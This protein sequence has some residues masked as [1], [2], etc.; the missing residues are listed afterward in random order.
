MFGL[1]CCVQRL[2]APFLLSG[3]GGCEHVAGN[4]NL[5]PMDQLSQ[6][7]ASLRSQPL[8]RCGWTGSACLCALQWVEQYHGVRSALSGDVVQMF[9]M[10]SFC[11]ACWTTSTRVLSTGRNVPKGGVRN[12][13]L[14]LPV[15]RSWPRCARAHSLC[16]WLSLQAQGKPSQVVR[17]A[18]KPLQTRGEL[19]LCHQLVQSHGLGVRRQL[20]HSRSVATGPVLHG[21]VCVCSVVVRL[22][23]V[24]GLDIVDGSSKL[25]L[26]LLWQVHLSHVHR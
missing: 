26:A 15:Q 18:T 12:L 6:P 8:P 25:A 1:R 11:F 22:V 20:W 2:C 9:A 3:N 21:C 17:H 23:N 10:V 24:S 16:L 5:A 14:H 13:T 7:A 4:A 19:Q